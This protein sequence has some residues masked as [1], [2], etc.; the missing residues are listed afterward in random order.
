AKVLTIDGN[1]T[2]RVFDIGRVKPAINVTISG[3]TIFNGLAGVLGVTSPGVTGGGV[4]SNSSGTVAII[5][6]SVRS[7]FAMSGGGGVC[8]NGAGTLN[9]LNSTVDTNFGS[10]FSGGGILNN[11]TGA[12][13]VINS[14]LSENFAA[15]GGAIFNNGTGTASLTNCT[16]AK[17]AA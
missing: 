5:S 11:S 15:F 2:F 10:D 6:S 8:N 17:N 4:L 7:S 16:I 14:T 12:V 9:V 13:N 1:F 3:L